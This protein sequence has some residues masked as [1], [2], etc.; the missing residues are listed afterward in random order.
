MTG[1][2]FGSGKLIMLAL[3]AGEK[4]KSDPIILVFYYLHS[5]FYN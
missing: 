4:E 2:Q 1:G 5:I 3:T